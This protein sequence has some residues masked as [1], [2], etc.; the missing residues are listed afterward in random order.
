MYKTLIIVVIAI[1]TSIFAYLLYRHHN[2]TAL[3]CGSNKENFSFGDLIDLSNWGVK[4]VST[5]THTTRNQPQLSPGAQ[6][7]DCDWRGVCNRNDGTMGWCA[8]G[9]CYPSTHTNEQNYDESIY[10]QK[11]RHHW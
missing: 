9:L 6:I 1:I 4:E 11:S 7:T 2:S 10:E 8:S 3:N 5:L